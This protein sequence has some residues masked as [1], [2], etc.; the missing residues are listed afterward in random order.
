MIIFKY[1]QHGI[2]SIIQ[3]KLLL[4]DNWTQTHR[5]RTEFDTNLIARIRISEWV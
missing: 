5:I 4:R 1:L 3:D 2:T